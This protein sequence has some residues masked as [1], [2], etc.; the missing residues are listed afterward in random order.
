MPRMN[1]F[2]TLQEA[3]FECTVSSLT[4]LAPLWSLAELHQGSANGLAWFIPS[5]RKQIN[6]QEPRKEKRVKNKKLTNACIHYSAMDF[7]NR[8]AI[9]NRIYSWLEKIDQSMNEKECFIMQLCIGDSADNY[10][11]KA[12]QKKAFGFSTLVIQTGEERKLNF[13]QLYFVWLL[14][15]LTLLMAWECKRISCVFPL[16]W[17]WEN[18]RKQSFTESSLNTNQKRWGRLNEKMPCPVGSFCVSWNV[19]AEFFL[20]YIVSFCLPTS[21]LLALVMNWGFV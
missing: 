21:L 3:R 5:L 15:G 8:L 9:P 13:T 16:R 4:K 17:M 10:R 1:G 20:C 6:G 12:T 7:R 14:V 19:F 11:Q 18:G 2:L